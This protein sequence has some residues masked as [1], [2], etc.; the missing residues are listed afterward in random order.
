M[1][2]HLTTGRLESPVE[3]LARMTCPPHRCAV[4][5]RDVRRDSSVRHENRCDQMSQLTC[6]PRP[7]ASRPDVQPRAARSRLRDQS[8]LPMGL[9]SRRHPMRDGRLGSEVNQMK[10]GVAS[11]QPIGQRRGQNP[12]NLP[13]NEKRTP[14]GVLFI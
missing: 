4:R 3:R 14:E 13:E 7:R 6:R 1:A 2:D 5:E 10:G 12:V 11:Q 9:L 8:E